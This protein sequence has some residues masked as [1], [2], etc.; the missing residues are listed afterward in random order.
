M[1]SF[2]GTA[3]SRLTEALESGWFIIIFLWILYIVREIFDEQ[4]ILEQALLPR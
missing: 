2:G 4:K 1:L 3:I